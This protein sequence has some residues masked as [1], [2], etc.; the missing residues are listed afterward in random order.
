MNTRASRGG[1]GASC[2]DEDDHLFDEPTGDGSAAAAS[3]LQHMASESGGLSPQGS[4]AVSEEGGDAQF[5]TV[6]KAP[7][8]PGRPKRAAA[9]AAVAE[10]VAAELHSDDEDEGEDAAEAEEASSIPVVKRSAVSSA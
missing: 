2:H 4:G 8:G 9:A 7:A 6:E 1:A 3:A 5:N 10:I